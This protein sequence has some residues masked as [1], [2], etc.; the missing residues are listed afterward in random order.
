[1]GVA[2][3]GV[4]ERF[5][6]WESLSRD[7]LYEILALRQEVFVVEQRCFYRDADGR[8]PDAWHL[9]WRLEGKLVAYLRAFAPDAR[10]E[11]RIGRVLTA[12]AVRGQGH[13][14]PLMRAGLAAV[15]RAFG[16]GPVRLEAQSHL[17]AYY[18]SLGFVLAGEPYVE[19]GIPHISMRKP[20]II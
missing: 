1:M 11:A 8:D 2:E 18:G 4:E 12:M 9:T 5:G 7:E 3:V 13:G 6:P 19:D 10:G 17:A 16:A 14:R 15:E 20:A